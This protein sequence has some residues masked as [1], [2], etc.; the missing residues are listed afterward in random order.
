M[1]Q[2]EPLRPG[3]YHFYSGEGAFKPG[4]DSFLLGSFPRL[5]PKLRVCDL[6]SGTGLLGLLLLQR[7]PDLQITGLELQRAA[8]DIAARAAEKNELSDRLTTLCT[9]LRE[10]KALLPTGSFDLCISNP[11]YFSL[12]SGKAAPDNAR[13]TARGE[14]ECTLDDVCRAASYLLRWS[15]TFCVVYRPERLTDLLCALRINGLE[16]KRL[17]L[18]EAKPSSAP[19]LVLVEARRGGKPGLSIEPPLI[20]S[21]AS[22]VPTADCDTAYF[23]TKENNS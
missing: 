23:R 11:P 3:G 15:G 6:G 19:S 18:V 14:A 7:Q 9:D 2:W 13:Q 10:V 12:G 8:A 16:P 1:E 5:R 22:G 17:R 4:T 21:D 20:L